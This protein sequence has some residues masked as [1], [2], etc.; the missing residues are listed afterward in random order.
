MQRFNHLGVTALH[1]ASFR[2]HANIVDFLLSQGAAI[3]LPA[4]GCNGRTSLH[5]ACYDGRLQVVNLLLLRGADP[6]LRDRSHFTPLMDATFWGHVEVV[7]HLLKHEGA[8]STIDAQSH[9]GTT[10]LWWACYNGV[11]ETVRLL[12]EA[13]ANPMLAD[14]NGKTAVDIAKYRGRNE[15]VTILEVST[16]ICF[17]LLSGGP[18]LLVNLVALVSIQQWKRS[19]IVAKT[20]RLIEVARHASSSATTAAAAST[21][22]TTT[23]A[24]ATQAEPWVRERIAKGKA[25][26]SVE[27]WEGVDERNDD[28]AMV[29]ARAVLE[30]V[31]ED[32]K[33]ELFVELMDMMRM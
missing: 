6:A 20:R 31:M 3:D 16:S 1:G 22:T 33:A 21:A 10:A 28:A 27:I 13:G 30:Y 23:I 5:V 4:E 15:H 9:N 7:R 11:T 19:Y 32:L 25:L 24:G 26:P 17:L 12:L 2:G 29:E 8:R 14:D 18:T